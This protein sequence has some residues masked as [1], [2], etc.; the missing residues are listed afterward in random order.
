MPTGFEPANIG[1]KTLGVKPLL[2]GTVDPEVSL[3][4][5]QVALAF[6]VL[7]RATP[8]ILASSQS[9]K[10]KRVAPY[11]KPSNGIR[12]SINAT[13]PITFVESYF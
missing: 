6:F 4:A 9:I 7:F 3:Q 1:M 13:I 2:N 8:F 5:P 10:G 12:H 11:I